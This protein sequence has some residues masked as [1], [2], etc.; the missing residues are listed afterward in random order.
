MRSS[1]PLVDV[2]APR[3]VRAFRDHPPQ[4]CAE[5]VTSASPV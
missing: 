1:L 3:A 4:E 5:G 2:P